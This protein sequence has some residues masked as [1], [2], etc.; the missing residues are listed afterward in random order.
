MEYRCFVSH[1]KLVAICQRDCS[2]YFDFLLDE[3]DCIVDRIAAFF[4]RRVQGNFSTHSYVFDVY[5]KGNRVYLLDFNPFG[6]VTDS[7]LFTWEELFL[8]HLA[9]GT[10]VAKE[11][12][13]GEEEPAGEDILQKMPQMRIV[14]QQVIQPSLATQYGVPVEEFDVSSEGGLEQLIR[15]QQLQAESYEEGDEDDKERIQR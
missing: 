2:Q 1:D 15:L 8:W 6:R 11:G 9:V 7:L 14:Q 10:V 5:I 13:E 3:Q 4:Q 12:L